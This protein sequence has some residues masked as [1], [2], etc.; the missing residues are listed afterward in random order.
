MPQDGGRERGSMLKPTSPLAPFLP[1]LSALLPPPS[2]LL[3][4]SLPLFYLRE[5]LTPQINCGI[6]DTWD[7]GVFN[8]GNVLHRT[9]SSAAGAGILCSAEAG[10]RSVHRIHPAQSHIDMQRGPRLACLSGCIHTG[11]PRTGE[12]MSHRMKRPS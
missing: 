8:V 10:A 1:P 5:P 4:R 9:C 12:E 2:P 11:R 7:L 3:Y 6:T